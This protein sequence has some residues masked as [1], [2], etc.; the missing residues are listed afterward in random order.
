MKEQSKNK[1]GNENIKR[2][3]AMKGMKHIPIILCT[4]SSLMAGGTALGQERP[5]IE[6]ILQQI[7]LHNREL[8]AATQLAR[9]EKLEQKSSNN[10][11]DP[12]LSYAHLWDS[13]D[14]NITVGELVVSQSFDFPT[15][16]L[17]RGGM[18][19]HLYSSI[20]AATEATR[21]RILLEAKLLCIEITTLNRQ[22]KLLKERMEQ[23][24]K[25]AKLYQKRLQEGDANLI[26]TNK[27]ELER[28][29][30]RTEYRLGEIAIRNKTQ[31]LLALNGNQPLL[32]GRPTPLGPAV[33]TADTLGLD[34]FKEQP[35]PG[36]L[37]TLMGELMET[38]PSLRAL[39]SRQLAAEKSI[40]LNKQGWLPRLELGYRRNTES[41]H[42]LNGV[43]VGFSFPLF[44]NRS[45]VKSARSQATG[46]KLQREDAQ[47]KEQ[48]R[49]S[50]LYEE[51]YQL[52]QSIQEYQSTLSA[53]QNLTLLEKAL[54]EGQIS[55]I[56]YFVEVSIIYQSQSNLFALEGEYQRAV[57]ELYRSRL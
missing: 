14:K 12:T 56:D 11:P 17:S 50:S 53:Q 39:K 8:Q 46:L 47:D 6:G 43:V 29:N 4:L 28:L 19:R 52:Q 42:P 36:D 40:G 34:H 35:L 44:E 41:G 3:K 15:R 30:A 45:K 54:M 21:Q 24:E 27:I 1:E 55:L 49:L 26:E 57:A 33:P 31:Q 48:A 22:Q 25:L 5:G 51:A 32:P 7:E 2:M 13:K 18:N 37:V 16:Y 23:A 10:L 9:A 20:D 38:D